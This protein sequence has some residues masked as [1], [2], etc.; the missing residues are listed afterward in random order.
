MFKYFVSIFTIFLLFGCSSKNVFTPKVEPK[1]IGFDSRVFSSIEDKNIFSIKFSDGSILTKDANRYELKL[2]KG[3]QAL[4]KFK[5]LFVIA[6]KDGA[7]K[8]VSKDLKEKF[9]TKYKVAVASATL[10]DNLLAIILSNNTIILHDIK[11]DKLLFKERLDPVFTL[12]ARVANPYFLNDLIIFPTLDGRLL[13]MNKNDKKIIKDFVVSI[14][15]D[16]NNIIFL[17]AKDNRLLAATQHGII[18]IDPK[19]VATF[20]ESL[21]D[22]LFLK[23]EIYIFTKDGSIVLT[24]TNLNTIKEKKFPFALFSYAT[25]YSDDIFVLL[26]NGYMIRVDKDLD[27]HIVYK[28]PTKIDSLVFFAKDKIYIGSNYIDLKKF[29]KKR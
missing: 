19:N 18:L 11:E 29:S 22:L 6:G 2:K 1:E 13:V 27:K 21:K 25:I 17:D 14:D 26:K 3:Y 23:D 20:N 8:I 10:Q 24:D 4:N 28:L 12:D 16:F 5:D 9:V 7:L 15:D